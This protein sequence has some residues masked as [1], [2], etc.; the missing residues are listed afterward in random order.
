M[1]VVRNGTV[2][3]K[4]LILYDKVFNPFCYRIL[5]FAFAKLPKDKEW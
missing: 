1:K 3:P 4:K 5:I 2:K